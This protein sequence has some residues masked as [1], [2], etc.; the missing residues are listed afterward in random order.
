MKLLNQLTRKHLM[1]NKKR[2]IVTIIGVIL[3][4]ALMMGVG[5]LFSSVYKNI[6]ASILK[7]SGNYHVVFHDINW[8]DLKIIENNVNVE[9]IQYHQLLSYARVSDYEDSTLFTVNT[10]DKS[11][12]KNINLEEGK[13]PT[14]KDEIIVPSYL[15]HYYDKEYHL[16]DDI[17]FYFGKRYL[18]GKEVIG[19]E[20]NEKETW[21]STENKT[22]KIVG[23]YDTIKNGNDTL[24]PCFVKKTEEEIKSQK[25]GITT[26]VT[27][28][29]NR[30]IRKKA[31]SIARHIGL[32][33]NFEQIE[34]HEEL[35]SL[36]GQSK[37]GNYNKAMISI[38]K[39]ILLLVSVACI[40]VIYNSFQISVME[41]KKQFGLF[42][43]IGATKKQLRYTVFYE[44]FII[45]MIGVPI[46]ILG[47][48][49]GIDVVIS[50]INHFLPNEFDPP[51]TLAI[52]ASFVMIPLIFILFVIFISAL[53][54]A[55]R[56]SKV[57]PIE[58][59]RQNDD[60]KIKGK[61]VETNKLVE[62]LFGVE[63]M[64]AL[65]NMKRNKKKYRITIISIFISV[66]L[67]LSFST[68]LEY[69]MKGA[70]SVFNKVDFDISIYVQDRSKDR[71]EDVIKQVIYH[72]AVKK[73]VVS[74]SIVFDIDVLKEEQYQPSYYELQEKY[75][76]EPA[77]DDKVS[78]VLY[79]YCLR[80][81]NYQELKE[82]FHL[83][84]DRPIFINNTTVDYIDKNGDRKIYSGPIIKEETLSSISVAYWDS[85]EHNGEKKKI[86]NIYYTDYVPFGFKSLAKQGQK[87]M[88][89]NDDL[90]YELNKF[91]LHGE[92]PAIY[93]SEIT[94]KAKDIDRLSKDLK[95]MEEDN[96]LEFFS[97]NNV[98]EGQKVQRNMFIV[99]QI[100]LYGF[101][102]L[103]TL[104]GV[105][106]VFNTINT[107]LILRKK[108][109][110]MLRSVGLTPHGF[111]KILWFE[112]IFFVGKAL[113]YALPVSFIILLVIDR[114]I[115][116]E[117]IIG[118]IL[119]P[120]NAVF[121]AIIFAFII[122]LIT[123]IYSTSKM[124]KENILEEIRDENI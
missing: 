30:D 41:R 50:C 103:V 71:L 119:V 90:F 35:L 31:E 8:D 121:L 7:D 86:E 116:K 83:D 40:I 1:M 20:V 45:A 92:E 123:S 72:P 84:S 64:L 49:L 107:S 88:I 27:F 75:L 33:K 78:D 77:I 62:K 98:V 96:V 99:V 109:F 42:A 97:V 70:D 102:T 105:T 122:V 14:A 3:S 44:A 18:D 17:T 87:M 21:K 46:G 94:L 51:L 25:N 9:S 2:T 81:E 82:K 63:G 59:I 38:V 56:A 57:T 73:S 100:L 108:E 66:V 36:Y 13:Y 28:K 11:Y 117:L 85:L 60:I 65:K 80:D 16:G 23:F 89:V 95:K 12:F 120:W 74:D 29:S 5:L 124:R 32:E 43:S 22:Y 93:G 118:H 55:I 61:K 106:S 52:N 58:A 112:S 26:W 53:L 69:G 37:Y 15:K 6:E 91:S 68:I 47:A 19:S 10:A 54:P 104:I 34:Y 79:V 111:K 115:G 4:C 67:F 39:V 76:E 114:I 110:G 113:F 101:I 48:Y 24:S